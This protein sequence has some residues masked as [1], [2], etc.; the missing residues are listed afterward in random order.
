MKGRTKLIWALVAAGTIAACTEPAPPGRHVILILLDTARADR[1]GCYDA[2]RQTSP[3]LDALAAGGA[4]FLN[5]FTQ[6]TDTRSALPRLIYSRHFTPPLFP[7]SARVPYSDPSDLF[8]RRDAEAI[9]L[10]AVL[11][12]HGFHTAMISA[13]TWLKPQTQFAREFVEAHDL[14]MLLDPERGYPHPRAE[15]VV[16]FALDWLKRNRE[17]DVFLYLHLMDIH[18]P[19][20]FD[21]DAAALFEGDDQ[22]WR[23]TRDV[24]L[25]SPDALGPAERSVLD[26]IYDGSVR[27]TDRHLGRLFDLYRDWGVLES[28]LIAVT[29]DH[30]EHLLERPGELGHGGP[31]YDVVARVPL[32]VSYPSAPRASWSMWRRRSSVCSASSC[33]VSA[34]S[35]AWTCFRTP[36]PSARRPSA[37]RRSEPAASR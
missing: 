13:H 33:R 6:A 27:Y 9:S 16:D 10:P 17:R 32:V 1:F 25:D 18:S 30:G 34:R 35:T 15:A 37:S 23:G 11:A 36:P 7:L 22:R 2:R 12:A 26:A 31:W 5:H 21:D 29:S 4:V 24:D 19:R 20:F 14:S 8:R 28:T 3:N